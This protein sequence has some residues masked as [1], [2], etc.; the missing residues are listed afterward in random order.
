MFRISARA[1]GTAA[2][3]CGRAK[4][5]VAAWGGSGTEGVQSVG[6]KRSTAALD[7]MKR[8]IVAEGAVGHSWRDLGTERRIH[9]IRGKWAAP[10][11]R[12]EAQRAA[13]HGSSAGF[14]RAPPTP[15]P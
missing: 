7:G 10:V 1:S 4:R 15:V 6:V 2:V 3:V 12:R 9:A 5:Q 8:T 11:V 13:R 14:R